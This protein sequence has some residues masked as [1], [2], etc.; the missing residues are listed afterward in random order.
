MKTAPTQFSITVAL[1]CAL[2]FTSITL[3]GFATS[4]KEPKRVVLAAGTTVLAVLT[5]DVVQRGV[6]AADLIA[7]IVNGI[8]GAV[9]C[10]AEMEIGVL[11]AEAFSFTVSKSTS[12]IRR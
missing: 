3:R 12:P 6:K 7:A 9:C 8:L 11:I 5:E 10:S 2:A 4:P 1:V